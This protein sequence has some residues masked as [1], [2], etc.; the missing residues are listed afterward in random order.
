MAVLRKNHLIQ[1]RNVLNEIRANNMTLQEL[2]FFSIYLS[3]I[4]KDKPE[5]TRIVRFP[6]GDFKAIMEL[7]RIDIGYMKNVTN[8]LLCK[9]VNV[10]DERG[11]FVGFQLFKECTVSNDDNGE[12]YVEIDAHDKA[13]P[14]MFE[15]KNRYF[16]YKLWNALRLR[17]V[18]QLRMYEVLKQYEGVGERIL[19]I[20]EL[21]GLLGI[22]KD[23]YPRYNNFKQWV[24][25]PCLQALAEHTDIKFSYEP[26][27][28]RGQGGK[29]QFLRFIISKNEDYVDQL[30]LD[31]YIEES[32]LTVESDAEAD[33][34]P[35]DEYSALYRERIEFFLEACNNEFS[36][37]QVA[38]LNN[39]LKE[40]KDVKFRDET[41]C[42]DYIYRRYIK[43]D[44]QDKQTKGTDNQVK[45]RFGLVR[46]F[47]RNAVE[48]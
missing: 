14:L 44:L 16:S 24:L 37:E 32:R 45:S 30:T 13:L 1:K 33:G 19:S 31:M 46:Y 38:E 17:S 41:V 11:G 2:R 4:H 25:E 35:E 15:F 26:H 18:N 39:I 20:E 36:F 21:R 48:V 22:A 27:G 29:I 34:V 42:Y 43:M 12:W 10:P 47:I 28:K 6:M 40:N 9:V 23:E 7:G 3:K 8:S 5:E